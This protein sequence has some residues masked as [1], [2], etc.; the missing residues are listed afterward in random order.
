MLLAYSLSIVDGTVCVAC[1]QTDFSAPRV[2]TNHWPTTVRARD[3]AHFL[4]IPQERL[5][6]CAVK[7]SRPGEFYVTN[8]GNADGARCFGMTGAYVLLTH[9]AQTKS[10]KTDIADYPAPKNRGKRVEYRDGY[11]FKDSAKGWKRHESM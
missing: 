9:G 4:D 11:W 2:F 6:E 1:K 8:P 5:A 7:E 10:V 3:L